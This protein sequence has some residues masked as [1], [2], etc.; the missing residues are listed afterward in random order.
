MSKQ[1]MSEHGGSLPC[2]N[3]GGRTSLLSSEEQSKQIKDD[4]ELIK[5]HKYRG[6]LRANSGRLPTRHQWSFENVIV[7]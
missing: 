3:S 5:H 4:A 1:E 2:T 6:G 7:K